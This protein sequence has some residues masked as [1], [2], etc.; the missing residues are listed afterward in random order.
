MQERFKNHLIIWLFPYTNTNCDPIPSSK[1]LN[2]VEFTILDVLRVLRYMP[3]KNLTSPD[4]IPYI[5]LKNCRETL[6][7]TITK[8]FRLI[9]DSMQIP[10]YW[11]TSII[12]PIFKKG[13][14]TNVN[15]YRPI[16]LTCTLCRVFERTIAS[17]I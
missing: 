11:R 6:A 15:N 9:L 1:T 17:Y 7:S 3:N 5:L 12:I 13:E 16:S 8:L 14:K 4:K 10:K 2:D